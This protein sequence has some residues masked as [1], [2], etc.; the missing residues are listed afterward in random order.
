M[1]VS[2]GWEQ[3]GAS[4][5][6]N[7]VSIIIIIRCR[8]P[9]KHAKSSSAWSWSRLVSVLHVISHGLIITVCFV[10]ANRRQKLPWFCACNC[11]FKNIIIPNSRSCRV[12]EP[13]PRRLG[14]QV[15]HRARDL[16][17]WL[18]SVNTRFRGVHKKRWRSA[19]K[20]EI[21]NEIPRFAQIKSPSILLNQWVK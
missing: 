11:K 7:K 12:K 17:P 1:Y 21:N 8:F 2:S 19:T 16:F 20:R 13:P 5:W 9:S 15:N 6:K 18:K 4:A 3:M 14:K 10:A